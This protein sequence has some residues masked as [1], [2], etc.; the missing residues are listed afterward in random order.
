[1]LSL[2]GLDVDWDNPNVHKV[3]KF[4][5][6]Q[7]D[8]T[9][10]K[11]DNVVQE[12]AE[13]KNEN[14]DLKAQ[15]AELTKL[16]KKSKKTGGKPK[17]HSYN[18]RKIKDYPRPEQAPRKVQPYT[19]EP[20]SFETILEEVDEK[21]CPSCGAP[22]AQTTSHYD[23]NDGEDIRDSRWC[24]VRIKTCG[25]YCKKCGGMKYANSP[26]FLP[27]MQLGM[28]VLSQ[29]SCMRHLTI[30]YGKIAKFFSMIYR[31]NLPISRIENADAL[32]ST[33]LEPVY[34]AA[35]QPQ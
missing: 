14:M 33:K 22:L 3:F 10:S 13:I 12:N 34:N 23:R 20:E 19:Q 7:F 6:E 16:V 5:S 31:R 15:I 24:K 30:S 1:M 9:N 18:A 32:V 2:D 11:Y 27:H 4:F 8:I 28:E 26:N 21:F 25:R 29:I 35:G 17:R